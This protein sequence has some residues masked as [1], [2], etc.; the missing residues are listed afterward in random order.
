MIMVSIVTAL[1]E[2]LWQMLHIT[3]LMPCVI[4][5][6][7]KFATRCLFTDYAFMQGLSSVRTGYWQW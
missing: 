1:T 6:L 4:V 7:V 2:T 3:R 5:D